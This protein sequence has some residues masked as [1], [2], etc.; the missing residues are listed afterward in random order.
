MITSLS[1]LVNSRPTTIYSQQYKK[2][3]FDVVII[4]PLFPGGLKDHAAAAV[5]FVHKDISCEQV[6]SY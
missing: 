3:I 4:I 5:V 2:V 1:A 6:E